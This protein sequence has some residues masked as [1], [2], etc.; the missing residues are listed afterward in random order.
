MR[1]AFAVFAGYVVMT[2]IVIGTSF[3]VVV[4]LGERYQFR[5]GT[6]DPAPTVF[7]VMS[8]AACLAGLLGGRLTSRIAQTKWR[9]A[10]AWLVGVILV[11]GT[12]SVLGDW[13]RAQSLARNVHSAEEIARM[14]LRE[15]LENATKPIWFSAVVPLIGVAAA[16]VG[17]RWGA[18]APARIP[19]T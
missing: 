4:G 6:L 15:K 11:L 12:F 16:A 14:S 13:M 2:A 5:E 1:I 9:V 3:A 10:R 17:C 8:V 18:V 19:S 7:I